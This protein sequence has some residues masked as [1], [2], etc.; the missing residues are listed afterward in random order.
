[1]ALA[2]TFAGGK[3]YRRSLRPGAVGP[4]VGM[5]RELVN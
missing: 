4:W 3:G 5:Q 1:M 2:R